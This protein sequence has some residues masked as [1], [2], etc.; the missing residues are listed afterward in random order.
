ME[1]TNITDSSPQ[2][3]NV[4]GNVCTC[5]G[6]SVCVFILW[7]RQEKNSPGRVCGSW[8][9]LRRSPPRWP[10]EGQRRSSC[11]CSRRAS[12]CSCAWWTASHTALEHVCRS[13]ANN[14]V[15]E[16]H[17]FNTDKTFKHNDTVRVK[18]T[19]R[20]IMPQGHFMAFK[21]PTYDKVRKTKRWI[22]KGQ[23]QSN[24]PLQ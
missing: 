19:L 3:L 15:K 10:H 13:R 24:V 5:V 4:S 17:L 11:R 8:P 12:A 7:N 22:K 2:T 21:K 16:K 18:E 9:V 14:R 1:A 20:D 6:G 23:R